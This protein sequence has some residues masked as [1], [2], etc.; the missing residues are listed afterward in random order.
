MRYLDVHPL[1]IDG[2]IPDNT[3]PG[4]QEEYKALLAPLLLNSALAALK[5]PSP[6]N[7]KYAV[8][9]TTRALNKLTLS[10]ADKG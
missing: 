2:V 6:A 1:L 10:D 4:L 5:A 9:N 3:D 7:Y 8:Q